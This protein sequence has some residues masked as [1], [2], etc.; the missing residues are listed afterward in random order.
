V[1][2]S[3]EGLGPTGIRERLDEVLGEGPAIVFSDLRDGSCG[4]AAR[5]ACVGPDRVLITG[6]NLPVLLDF[7]MKRQLPL[8]ELVP[9]LLD[10]ARSA[11]T[12]APDPG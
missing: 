7:V 9:R 3:N 1:A 4:M 12:A 10:R 8:R 11:I 2:V 6:V 5:Q